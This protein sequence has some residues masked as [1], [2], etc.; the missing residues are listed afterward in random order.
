[1]RGKKVRKTDPQD[2]SRFGKY[3]ISQSFGIDL[4]S[5]WIK[6][7]CQALFIFPNNKCISQYKHSLAID[8]IFDFHK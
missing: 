5:H 2:T 8:I 6:P 1:M 4:N 3:D 7:N